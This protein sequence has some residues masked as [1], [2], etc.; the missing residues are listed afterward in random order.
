MQSSMKYN[1][2]GWID[3]EN[4]YNN[5]H[6]NCVIYTETDVENSMSMKQS[7]P[8]NIRFKVVG[9]KFSFQHHN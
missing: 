6:H 3:V 4:C 8:L 2:Y 5:H 9:G 7:S 1:Q